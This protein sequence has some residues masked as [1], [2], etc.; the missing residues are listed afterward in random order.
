MNYFSHEKISN[1]IIRIK[2]VTQTA[3]YLINGRKKA[4]LIDTGS[5]IGNIREYIDALTNLPYDVILTHGHVDHASG[6][7]LFK[8]KKIYL[9]E[10]DREIMRTHTALEM[11]KKYA[12]HTKCLHKLSDDDFV[13]I[14]DSS[15]TL[16]LKDGQIFDL[17]DI[18]L[19]V[20][21]TPGHTQGMCMILVREERIILF[22]DGCGA[23]V[24][25]IEDCASTVEE[26]ASTLQ[27]IKKRENEYNYILRNH[28]TCESD[29]VI[30]DNV[31]ECCENVL[32]QNDDHQLAFGLAFECEDAY[33]AKKRDSKTRRRVDGREGNLTYRLSKIYKKD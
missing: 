12:N 31:I 2:D 9:H 32:K 14:Y 28:G 15:K 3:M 18:T 22:G 27:K 17:G 4:C 20:I 16:L 33:F 26:Y 29:K 8:D 19:E 5:G 21:H 25:L 23:N 24:M 7:S 13:S 11:R 10:Q 1:S 30:L 6:C